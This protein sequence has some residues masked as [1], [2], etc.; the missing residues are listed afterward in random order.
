MENNKKNSGSGIEYEGPKKRLTELQSKLVL[1]ADKIKQKETASKNSEIKTKIAKGYAQ[2]AREKLYK[3][4]AQ[5]AVVGTIYKEIKQDRKTLDHNI[6]TKVEGKSEYNSRPAGYTKSVGNDFRRYGQRINKTLKKYSALRQIG[7]FTSKIRRTFS[8]DYKLKRQD[9]LMLEKYTPENL[10]NANRIL[11]DAKNARL[12]D[13]SAENYAKLDKTQ[14]EHDYFIKDYNK[15]VNAGKSLIVADES[16]HN[17]SPEFI[18]HVLNEKQR[19][20]N[21]ELAIL[22]STPEAQKDLKFRDKQQKLNKD[23]AKIQIQESYID[24]VIN[25]NK[26]IENSSES[27]KLLQAIKSQNPNNKRISILNKKISNQ[28]LLQT[29]RLS[30][31]NSSEIPILIRNIKDANNK[32]STAKFGIKALPLDSPEQVA[33]ANQALFDARAKQK[34]YN[35]RFGTYMDVS[36]NNES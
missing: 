30:T 7:K 16:F 36:Q 26:R 28:K 12:K 34:A 10:K 11:Q 4:V 5:T 23:L 24:T 22:D 33:Q 20:R 19:L 1:A 21:K 17:K 32:L 2:A 6:N 13:P 31:P 15:I 27:E 35:K 9:R 8:N 14:K 18:K 29:L 25:K 3:A